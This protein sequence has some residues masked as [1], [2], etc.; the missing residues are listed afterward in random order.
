[1]LGE[2]PRAPHFSAR[3]LLLLPQDDP[4]HRTALAP[5]RAIVRR[6]DQGRGFPAIDE[7]SERP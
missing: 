2:L 4:P 6:S 7:K 1:M 3:Q 5:A